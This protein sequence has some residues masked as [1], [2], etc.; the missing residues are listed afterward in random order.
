MEMWTAALMGGMSVATS[1]AVGSALQ[2]RRARTKQSEI[3]ASQAP[4]ESV[5]TPLEEQLEADA[6]TLAVVELEGRLAEAHE[7]NAFLRRDRDVQKRRADEFF[8]V[9]E[10]VLKERD[11]WR[12]MWHDHGREHLEAQNL[13][14]NALTEARSVAKNALITIN[15]YRKK[16]GQE[17]IPFGLEPGEKPVGSAAKFRELLERSA[18]E[19]PESV[20]A[21][22][23]RDAAQERSVLDATP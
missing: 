4:A 23:L 1:V 10:L 6:H 11:Q 17:P 13:L 19:A 5:V 18:R 7:E 8:N 15:R 22:A 14:E 3:K 2:S 12:T 9:I 21:V 16:A 20:D